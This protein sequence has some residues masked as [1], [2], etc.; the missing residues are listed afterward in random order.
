MKLPTI[1]AREI[2]S[3]FLSP[4]AWVVLAVLQA[5]LSY[6]LLLLL[7]VFL[8][9]LP[10]LTATPGA[11]GLT[12]LVV[13]PLLQWAGVVLMLVVPLMTMR[14]ISEERRN[15]TLNLLF[16]SP[17]SMTEIVLGKYLGVLL[18]LLCV[19]GLVTLL[20]LALL[21]GG[22]LDLGMLAAGLLGLLLLTASYAAAGLYLST[23]TAQP[24]IAA[25][26]TFGLLLV[27]WMLDSSRIGDSG[28]VAHALTYLSLLGHF[29]DLV[30]GVFDSRDVIYYLLFITTFLVLSI[31]RLDGERLQG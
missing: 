29:N 5:V 28:A 22:S 4:L 23:L 24:A 7:E 10:T 17:L 21:L 6:V 19:V 14:L 31:R 1:A 13:A 18:F 11:P 26:G 20:V 3:I 2:R 9:E 30:R 15:G 8:R 16:S 12:A 27:L 25:I